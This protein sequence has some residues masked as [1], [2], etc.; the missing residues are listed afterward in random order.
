M[1]IYSLD[2]VPAEPHDFTIIGSGPAG[3]YLAQMLGQSGSSVLLIEQGPLDD[4][5]NDGEGYYEIDATGLDY[6]ALGERLAAFGGTS[7]HWGGMSRP[8]A[9]TVFEDRSFLNCKGWPIAYSEYEQHLDAVARWLGHGPASDEQ[10]DLNRQSG[11]LPG[12]STGLTPHLFVVRKGNPRRLNTELRPWVEA[13]RSVT[14]LASHR[15]IDM[16]LDEAGS[17]VS[18]LRII[19]VNS[20]KRANRSVRQVIIASG[21][22]ENAR[23]MLSAGRNLPAGNPL[24]GRHGRTGKTFMEHPKYTALEVYI[25][26]RFPLKDTG[27]VN[28][29]GNTA[30]LTAYSLA[31]PLFE[32]MKLPRFAVFFWGKASPHAQ[33]D[34]KIRLLDHALYSGEKAYR[35]S[36]PEFAFEQLPRDD[37][38]ISLSAKNDRH[39]LPLARMQ[40]TIGEDELRN[41]WKSIN[42]FAS[43][44][45][46]T[47]AARTRL[48]YADFDEFAETSQVDIQHHHMGS[49]A[50][51]VDDRSGVVDTNCRVHGVGN[52]YVAGSS[53]FPTG[54]YV[55]PTM[56]LLALADRLAN[57]LIELGR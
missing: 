13:S 51:S 44:L 21:G 23:L 45:S 32:T 12:P 11:F 16:T 10:A 37:S 33:V 36:L 9:P 30:S 49:T 5:L 1:I 20:G 8:L 55:N 24:T 47:G 40:W 50:M 53:V 43:L 39:G 54:D 2:D 48:M 52:L 41:Y 28:A 3:L 26:D 15:V 35:L 7:G 14:L 6:L 31:E 25:D 46:Q 34:E 42:V 19:G 27:W 4:P 56:N 22:I 18:S 57:H 29:D 38:F 17:S